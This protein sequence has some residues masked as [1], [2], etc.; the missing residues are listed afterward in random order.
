[1][2]FNFFRAIDAIRA[3]NVDINLVKTSMNTFYEELKEI[4]KK[5]GSNKET[6]KFLNAYHISISELLV[7]LKIWECLE[8]LRVYDHD[9]KQAYESYLKN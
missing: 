9:N 4:D 8:L 7:A 5:L 2:R 6:L 3:E 1:M